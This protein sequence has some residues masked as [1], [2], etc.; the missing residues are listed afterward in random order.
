MKK[1]WNLTGEAFDR[2]LQWL[3]PDREAA[4]EKYELVRRKLIRFFIGRGSDI[5]EELADTTMNRVTRVLEEDKIEDFDGDPLGFFFGVA[6]YV[7]KESRRKKRIPPEDL[8]ITQPYASETEFSCLDRCLKKCPVRSRDL[9]TRYYQKD[10]ADKIAA[11]QQLSDEIGINM[12]TL[13]L[14]VF[15]IRNSLREC[16]TDCVHTTAAQ[17]SP[18]GG[19]EG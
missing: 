1:E 8:L 2:L 17:K 14:K 13:R 16:V 15:R 11:R 12:N 6:K 5:S 3:S 4:A 10:G 18:L 19:L 7:Y 9:I